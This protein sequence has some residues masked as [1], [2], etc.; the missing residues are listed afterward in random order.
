MLKLT[1]I[2]FATNDA[3]GSA[4]ADYAT[5]TEVLGSGSSAAFVGETAAAQR[6][7]EVYG[8]GSEKLSNLQLQLL[9]EEPGVSQAE[10]EA[11]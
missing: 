11:Q 5:A 6:I 10:V 7:E 1:S 3:A 4:S 2:E 8:A 9:E